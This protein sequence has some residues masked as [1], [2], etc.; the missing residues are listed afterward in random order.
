MENLHDIYILADESKLSQVIRNLV[1]N[2]IK[3]TST[4][5]TV[6][7]S[8]YIEDDIDNNV[9]S[10][11]CITVTDTGAGIAKVKYIYNI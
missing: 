11:L 1:S 10:I 2:A 9:D 6:S 7:I 5:G 8:A 3:F 4:G